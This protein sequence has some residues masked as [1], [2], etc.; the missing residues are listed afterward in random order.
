MLSFT[1]IPRASR[2]STQC[3]LPPAWFSRS[4]TCHMPPPW[5]RS[6]TNR[7][8]RNKQVPRTFAQQ[9]ASAPLGTTWRAVATSSISSALTAYTLTE[10]YTSSSR[11]TMMI[12]LKSS[13]DGQATHIY[14]IS[15]ARPANL[16][17]APLP[18][19]HAFFVF[20]MLES[21]LSCYLHHIRICCWHYCCQLLG[22][23]VGPSQHMDGCPLPGSQNGWHQVD[24]N[25]YGEMGTNHP[26]CG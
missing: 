22:C 18:T 23:P 25:T 20:I 15:K 12:W 4:S 17:P 7:T 14:D 21:K 1:I 3:N 11:D 8:V 13:A 5:A 26:H 19:W 2:G 16:P 24:R 10:P 6:S 9:S